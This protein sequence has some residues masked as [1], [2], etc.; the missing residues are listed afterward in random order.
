MDHQLIDARSLALHRLVADK[1]AADPSLLDVARDN[2]QRWR[3]QDGGLPSAL[4]EWEALLGGKLDDITAVLTERSE[5]ASRLRQS[6]PFAGV[7]TD[8][9]RRTIYE[10]HTARAHHQGG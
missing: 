7:L 8:A 9:E 2:L 10:S 3:E 4:G 6:S 1:L 5:R